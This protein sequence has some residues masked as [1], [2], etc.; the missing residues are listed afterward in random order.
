MDALVRV[1][2]FV[3]V[4]AIGGRWVHVLSLNAQILSKLIGSGVLC[5][6]TSL[7]TLINLNICLGLEK[8]GVIRPVVLDLNEGLFLLHGSIFE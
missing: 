1:V 8:D 6:G 2:E 5:Q 3:P 4:S 7:V